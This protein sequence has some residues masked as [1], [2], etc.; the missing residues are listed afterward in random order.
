MKKIN[1]LI[2]K[3]Y[4]ES[5]R[6]FIECKKYISFVSLVFLFSLILGLLFPEIIR[7]ELTLMIEELVAQVQG[8]GGL[9]LMGFIFL[10]NMWVSF[11]AI[12]LG[13]LL[14]FMP[15]LMA[16]F[17]GYLVG[18]VLHEAIALEGILVVWR[19]FPH[20]IFELPAVLFAMGVGVKLGRDLIYSNTPA[21]TLQRNLIEA[22]RFYCFIVFPLLLIAAIIEGALIFLGA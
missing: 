8:M 17:N 15:V 6:F 18:F 1:K 20:G 2:E 4:L 11:L 7:D 12:A 14:G 21:K 3:N 13:I 16:I 5:Y 19:L 9:E 10:N 22:L